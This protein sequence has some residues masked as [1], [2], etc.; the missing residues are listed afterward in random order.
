M[1]KSKLAVIGAFAFSSLLLMAPAYA[2]GDGGCEPPPDEEP[3]K[4]NNGLG[5]G[6]QPAAGKSLN[7]NK[8]ENQVGAPG[9][10]SGKAQAPD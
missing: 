4:G 2:C 8:A 10:P 9:H 5:N 7:R 6:D 1:G 3:V